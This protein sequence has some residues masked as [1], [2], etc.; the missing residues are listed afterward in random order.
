VL[1]LPVEALRLPGE[2]FRF[3]EENG[4]KRRVDVVLG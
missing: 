3:I 4:V 2:R 1:W